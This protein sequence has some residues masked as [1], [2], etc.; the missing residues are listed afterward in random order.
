[1][2]INKNTEIDKEGMEQWLGSSNTLSEAIEILTE[3]F[4]GDYLVENFRED[5]SSYFEPDDRG[6]INR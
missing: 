1:M 4:N 5:V 3:I 6:D 2:D